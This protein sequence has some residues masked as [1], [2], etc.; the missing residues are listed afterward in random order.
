MINIIEL[1]NALLPKAK[2]LVKTV[3]KSMDM[4]EKMSFWFYKHQKNRFMKPVLRLF[5][6]TD[7]MRYW[8]AVDE[9][10]EICGITGLY[11]ERKD[12]EDTV[13]L[14]WFCVDPKYRGR[15]LGKK[16]LE[17]SIEKARGYGKKRLCLYTTTDPNE[18]GAQLLYEKYGFK[19]TKIKNYPDYTVMYREKVLTEL[20]TD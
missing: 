17:F 1:D 11:N 10:A 7:S 12:R 19:I 15:G 6:Y 4:R 20:G 9:R 16:L 18:A 13:W 14:C 2:K 5:G 3:F 8:V